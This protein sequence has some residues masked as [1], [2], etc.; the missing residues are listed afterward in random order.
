MQI[1]LSLPSQTTE[2]PDKIHARW[3]SDTGPQAAQGMSLKRSKTN[4]VMSLTAPVYCLKGVSRPQQRKGNQTKPG[5]LHWVEETELEF[6]EVE[7]GQRGGWGWGRGEVK[8][9][10]EG[11]AARELQRLERIPWNFQLSTDNNMHVRKPAEARERTTGKEQM[12]QSSE[13][14][15]HWE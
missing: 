8:F 9:R 11:W 7:V 2:K 12:K 13:F 15:Q 6:G 5:W 3:L 10:G 1:R 14:M 4:E